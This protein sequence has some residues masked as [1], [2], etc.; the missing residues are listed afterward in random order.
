MLRLDPASGQ[1]TRVG[2]FPFAGVIPEAVAFDNSSRFLAVASFDR[3]VP[4][5][6]AGSAD[7]WR[8]VGDFQDASRL[9]VAPTGVSIPVTRGAHSMAFIR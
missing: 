8:I 3:Q 2:D 7:F 5:A 1:L 6:S 9:E 4:Q